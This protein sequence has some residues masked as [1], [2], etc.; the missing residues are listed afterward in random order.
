MIIQ[1]YTMEQV[2]GITDLVQMRY[3]SYNNEMTYIP[4]K[5]TR[6][7]M[8]QYKLTAYNSDGTPMWV[9]TVNK[10]DIGH[11]KYYQVWIKPEDIQAAADN[12]HLQSMTHWQE[13]MSDA[14][15]MLN[16]HAKLVHTKPKNR[17]EDEV[18]A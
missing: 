7:T 9:E 13:K 6:E 18:N 3:D 11:M 16:K 15:D 10:R 1:D 12:F 14:R 17:M 5:V 8:K 2:T 4:F